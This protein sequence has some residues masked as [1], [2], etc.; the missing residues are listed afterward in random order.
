MKSIL[1]GSCE[2]WHNLDKLVSETFEL[3][4]LKSFLN[5][6]NLDYAK[7]NQKDILIDGT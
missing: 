1:E 7:M 5:N 3:L 4:N 6:V 2:K